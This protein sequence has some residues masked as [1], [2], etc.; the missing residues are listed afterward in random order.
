MLTCHEAVHVEEG[1]D[2]QGPVLRPQLIGGNDVGKTGRQVA[3]AQWHTLH[4]R[5]LPFICIP[6]CL[7]PLR[8]QGRTY[9]LHKSTDCKP[10]CLNYERGAEWLQLC[11]EHSV[12]D[13]SC[14]HARS[15]RKLEESLSVA[16]ASRWLADMVCLVSGSKFS[17]VMQ[18]LLLTEHH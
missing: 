9:R 10:V 4:N 12:Q 1:H 13:D 2:H 8:G 14:M 18:H 17:E 6:L 16:C 3:L 5:N 7:H 15:S 11:M